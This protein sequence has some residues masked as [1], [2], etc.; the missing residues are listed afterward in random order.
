[1]VTIIFF[2]FEK[3][4][5]TPKSAQKIKPVL[6]R[7]MKEAEERFVVNNSAHFSHFSDNNSAQSFVFQVQERP[8]PLN[9]L[10]R[11][12]TVQKEEKTHVI[13]SASVGTAKCAFRKEYAP[14]RFVK[15]KQQTCWKLYSVGL[16][17]LIHSFLNSHSGGR[18]W[19][20]NFLILSY[21]L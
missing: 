16:L 21:S 8:K 11:H 2:R 1:M 15:K 20:S 14:F 18:R 6:E 4:D 13:Y 9:R 3:L 19:I 17:V 5:I 10:H 12:W 7:W